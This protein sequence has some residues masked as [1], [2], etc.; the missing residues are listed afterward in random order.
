MSASTPP[1]T[2]DSFRKD[3]VHTEEGYSWNVEDEPS[4]SSKNI[5]NTATCASPG[6]VAPRSRKTKRKDESLFETVRLGIVNHQ[7]GLSIN[8]LLLLGLTHLLFPSLRPT[9]SRY[10]LLSYKDHKTGLYQPGS[11]DFKFVALWIVIFTGLR[12]GTMDYVLVPWARSLGIHKKKATIRFA[13]Q[14]WL[15]VFYSVF[16][17]VGIYLY[18][19]SS[20]AGNLSAMWVNF[21]TSSMTG[22]FKWYYLGQFAFWLQQ[23][24]VVHIEEKRK[25]HWQMFTHHIITCLLILMSYG[26]Y[27]TKVGHVILITMD[28]VDLV[29]PAAKMLKY[30]GYQTA[31]DFAFGVFILTWF[32]A[33]HVFYLMICWSV[34]S[35]VPVYIPS[36]CYDMST[37]IRLASDRENEIWNN[38][39]HAYKGKGP[40]CFSEQIRLS[41]LGLLLALQ[42]L[43]I[44]W[45]TMIM[46]VAYGVLTGKGAEDSRSDDED[47]EEEEEEEVQPSP[48]KLG[49]RV[50]APKEEEVG[51]EQL[52]FVKRSSPPAR[53]SKTR[54]SGI[55]IPGH[56]DHKELLGRIGCDKPGS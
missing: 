45:F 22:L 37:G 56:G 26:L 25:D 17:T 42:A 33:R 8:I 12:A 7:L 54:A 21:P 36:G 10:F 20:Y 32:V 15:I 52:R 38:V 41:F 18:A 50:K 6:E 51:V 53:R 55:S 4:L 16:W 30:A 23:I 43:T 31:C 29:L 14:A 9:T 40:V 47:E 39:M 27:Q 34:H 3:S 5:L 13:E 11:E 24:V 46:R 44:I 1:I 49:K 48:K 2:S 28:V 35:D 19:T